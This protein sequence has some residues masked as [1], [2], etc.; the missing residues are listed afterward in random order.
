MWAGVREILTCLW[1]PAGA[2][3][4]LAISQGL[5]GSMRR[6]VWFTFAAQC[7]ALWIIRNK[8]T[9]EGKVINKPADAIF[10]MLIYVRRWRRLTRRVDRE[11]L[12]SAMEAIRWLH[13][14][15]S[16]DIVA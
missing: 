5:T 13:S 14:R 1:N 11:L 2:G 16:T 15:L 8:L 3:D 12:D 6:V 10:Q 9:I 7:W 4:F